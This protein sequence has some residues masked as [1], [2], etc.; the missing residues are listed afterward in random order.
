MKKTNTNLVAVVGLA[1]GCLPLQ[2]QTYFDAADWL[3]YPSPPNGPN[4]FIASNSAPVLAG[5]SDVVNEWRFRNSGPG[6]PSWNLSAYDG[7]Y[8]QSDPEIYQAITGLSPNTQYQVTVYG[9][10]PGNVAYNPPNTKS[11]HGIEIS[12]NG[13]VS[14][15]LIDSRGGAVPY[16][17]DNSS[18][19]GASI[20]APTANVD[21]RFYSYVPT[22]A[23][24]D[25]SG[26]INVLIRVPQLLSDGSA[27][28]RFNL[29]GFAFAIPEPTTL[30]LA[31][32]G[33]AALLTFRRRS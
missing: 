31:G 2:A 28:D 15:D 25:G 13:G 23:M 8:G 16:W 30:A 20:A 19:L 11:R 6:T 29:D 21:T 22:I 9:V 4:L 12:V 10:Y 18:D 7:R 5:T 3:Q 27:Q 1:L 17:V 14:Y 32:L 33:A 24:T 26:N